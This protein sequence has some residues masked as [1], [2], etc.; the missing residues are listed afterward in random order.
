[1]KDELEAVK[2]DL[3]KEKQDGLEMEK[4]IDELKDKIQK[5][6]EKKKKLKKDIKNLE[7]NWD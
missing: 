4:R 3:G 7:E 5:V 6:K 1:M 2:I